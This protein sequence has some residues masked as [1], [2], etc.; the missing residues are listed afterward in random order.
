MN[1]KLAREIAEKITNEQLNEMFNKAKEQIKDWTKVS[2]VNKGMTKGVSW[3]LFTKDFSLTYSYHIMAKINMIRE[4]G[5]YLPSEL[6]P[7]KEKRSKHASIVHQ[8]PMF[9]K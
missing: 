2:S 9:F 6:L 7:T 5:E 3:N 4:F 8:E 1:R